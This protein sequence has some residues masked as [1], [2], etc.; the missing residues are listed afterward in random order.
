MRKKKQK[1]SVILH[2]CSNNG[3]DKTGIKNDFLCIIYRKVNLNLTILSKWD[4]GKNHQ[5]VK[6]VRIEMRIK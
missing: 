1:E 3:N 6:S 5:I 4:E 2:D